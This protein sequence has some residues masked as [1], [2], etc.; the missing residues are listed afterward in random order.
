MMPS[1]CEFAVVAL[2]PGLRLPYVTIKTPVLSSA[3]VE[4]RMASLYLPEVVAT[5]P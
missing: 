2:I 3:V 4:A 1:L 5:I